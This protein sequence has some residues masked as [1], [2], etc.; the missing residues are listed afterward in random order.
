MRSNA[1]EE[2]GGP[3]AQLW[4]HRD[5][6]SKLASGADAKALMRLLDGV[7]GVQQAAQAAAGGDTGALAEMVQKLMQ[8]EEGAR[9]AENIA[10]QAR[11][12]G[13]E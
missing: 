3:A 13:L 7:D 8:T 6:I 4:K 2:M 5:A 12:A 9:L 11:Q 1:F 10:R